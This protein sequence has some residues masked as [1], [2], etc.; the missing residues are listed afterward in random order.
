[1]QR[2]I[3]TVPLLQLCLENFELVVAPG[4]GLSGEVSGSAAPAGIQAGSDETPDRF[5]SADGKPLRFRVARGALDGNEALQ[6]AFADRR[7]LILW[8]GP[9]AVNI[10]AMEL[11]KREHTTLIVVDGTWKQASRIV[12][13]PSIEAA[14][15]AGA[16]TRVQFSAAGRSHYKFRREPQKDYL[17]SLESVAY[18]LRFLEPHER[19]ALAVSHLL[20]VFELMVSMQVACPA[21]CR[22]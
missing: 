14:V 20:R 2:M 21:S 9:G 22:C 11:E 13:E 18:C 15:A 16:V 8:P 12:S 5:L 10:E 17:S 6:R 19:G 3:G 1:M 7:A 4:V